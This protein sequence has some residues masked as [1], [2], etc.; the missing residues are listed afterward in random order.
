[1]LATLE[2]VYGKDINAIYVRN[3]DLVAPVRTLPDGRPYFGGAGANELNPDGG[4]GAYVIDN[5]DEGYNFN[6]TAQL[7]KNFGN[8]LES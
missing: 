5:T 2:F 8:G 1:L 7:R 6:I 4:S 3:A